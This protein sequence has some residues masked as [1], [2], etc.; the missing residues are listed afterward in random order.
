M[1][2]L[3][4]VA[5]ESDFDL[6]INTTSFNITVIPGPSGSGPD[7]PRIPPLPPLLDVG[8]NIALEDG[9]IALNVTATANANETASPNI[10][11]VIS[12]IHRG[13]HLTLNVITGNYVATAAEVGAGLVQITPPK[14][15]SGTLSI[16]IEAVATSGYALSTTS[17]KQTVG[18]YFDP[19]ADGV[20][21]SLPLNSGLEVRI[22]SAP[23]VDVDGS[24]VSLPTSADSRAIDW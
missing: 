12:D 17:E 2:Q 7:D 9:G 22:D 3:T 8:E 11:I 18:L 15:F 14:D 23:S 5:V 4:T 21:I 1:M 6:A 24:E 10:A 19:V 13:G 20:G 16:T